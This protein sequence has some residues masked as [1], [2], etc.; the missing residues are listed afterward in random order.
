[1]LRSLSFFAQLPEQTL[2]L[3]VMKLAED[4]DQIDLQAVPH[5][6]E[7]LPHTGRLRPDG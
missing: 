7:P 5:F 2:D 1:M 4:S 6:L 3:V